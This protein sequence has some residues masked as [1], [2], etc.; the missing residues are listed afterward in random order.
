MI[1]V[2]W[3]SDWD[4]LFERDHTGLLLK[5]MEECVDGDY[6]SYKAKG[7][8][9]LRQDFFGKSPELLELVKRHDGMTS[10]VQLPRGGHDPVKVY[11]AYQRAAE[12]KGRPDCD[13]PARRSRATASARA[14]KAR[15]I[16]HQRK[17]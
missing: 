10:L 16:T 11:N 8:A 14:A 3:G 15:N 7:G 5:R 6:Q 13:P 1:K 2:V 12:H 17:S 4:K 9:Y